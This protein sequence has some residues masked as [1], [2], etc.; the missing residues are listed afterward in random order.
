MCLFLTAR[1]FVLTV[2]C[3]N[4]NS[5]KLT[6]APAERREGGRYR[7]REAAKAGETAGKMVTAQGCLVTLES[8]RLPRDP[9][10]SIPEASPL[11]KPVLRLQMGK[12]RW[13]P[14][15]AG[16]EHP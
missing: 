2:V 13:R 5:S 8:Q 16:Q 4:T 3:G 9:R 1:Q 11:A 6:T 15:S 14:Q 10:P 12:Q 7:A